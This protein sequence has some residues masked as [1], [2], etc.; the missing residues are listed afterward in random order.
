MA[1]ATLP[2]HLG[3]VVDDIEA[4]MDE[5][6]AALGLRWAKLQRRTALRK[7]AEGTISGETAFVYSL[8]GPPHLEL[9]ERRA[10]TVFDKVG[11]HHIG[12]WCD[13]P[14]AESERLE[15]QGWPFESVGVK[16][17]GSWVGGLY[18]FSGS[19]GLRVELVDIASSGPRYV[20]F[21]NGGDYA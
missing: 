21:M 3:L 15:R 13:D 9:I 17:D 18:H 4:A 14:R 5:L 7:S 19:L 20:R 12:V 2:Y 16:P 11:L 8:D 10:A 6:S 1:I